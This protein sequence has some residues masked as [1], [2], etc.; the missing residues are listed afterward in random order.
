MNKF[1]VG[2]GILSIITE[3]LYD[4]PIVVF[5]EY[6][7]NSVDSIFRNKIN[8]QDN[9][10]KIW[11]EENSLFFLDNGAGIK[12]ENFELE[13][14][15]IGASNKKKQKN[16][17]YKGIGRLSGIPY[18]NELIFVNVTDYASGYAQ[19][20]TIDGKRYEQIKQQDDYHELSFEELMNKIGFY[21]EIQFDTDDI[22]KK[23]LLK[24]SDL[25]RKTNN[26]FLVI[27]KQISQVLKDL[28]DNR[29][30]FIDNLQWLLPV[31]F[32][33]ELYSS[34]VKE[35]FEDITDE[36]LD[37]VPVKFCN[38]FY[39]DQKLY[40]PITRKKL[41]HY[42]CKN[43]FKYAIGFHTFNNDKIYIDSKNDFS[44]IRIYIDNMLL[45]DEQELLQSLDYYGMLLH[46][47]N[48]QL[49]SVK[50]IGA[51]IYITD[52]LNICT[53]ARRTFIEVTDTNSLEFLRLLAEFVNTI[54]DTRY[55]MSNY[56][57]YKNKQEKNQSKLEELKNIALQNMIKLAKENVELPVDDDTKFEELSDIEKKRKIKKS[58]SYKLDSLLNE[59]LNQLSTYDMDNSINNFLDW[60]KTKIV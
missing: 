30:K 54:Y 36:K 47:V 34:D 12:K 44:G 24:Y 19:V 51:M 33:P 22:L 6:V 60:L 11:N 52:K 3:S 35:L 58:I 55:A 5:R 14:V 8:S 45:C 16:L 25:L 40:R 46:T 2:A 48:G 26:G 50:G 17:G 10:I 20:Y 15:K 29:E 21:K 42:V 32:Q 13:M 56:V 9:D 53:N 49:Q 43:N 39:N 28:I 27:L 4:N 37:S 41:R 38:I 59:Y 57:S 23:S 1:N 7:Q 18:C 31:D